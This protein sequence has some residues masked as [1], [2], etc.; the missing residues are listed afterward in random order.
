VSA[1]DPPERRALRETVRRFLRVEVKPHLAEW[2][3]AD[4]VRNQNDDGQ[5][6]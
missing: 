2:E 4:S 3:D 6:T 1:W 5:R